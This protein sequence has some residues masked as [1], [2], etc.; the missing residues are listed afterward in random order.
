M[1]NGQE[2]PQGKV[3]LQ[4]RHIS[5]LGSPTAQDSF[6]FAREEPCLC[7]GGGLLLLYS[8]KVLKC[9]KDQKEEIFA[10]TQ[11]LP[12]EQLF[13]LLGEV[14]GGRWA[15]VSQRERRQEGEQNGKSEL[16]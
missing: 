1:F 4:R 14:G 11:A 2:E 16:W 9:F 8:F 12:S 6:L 3:A 10:S 7:T 5:W 13:F 15:L